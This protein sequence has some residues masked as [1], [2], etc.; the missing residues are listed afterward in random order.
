MKFPN[1]YNKQEYI[2]WHEAQFKSDKNLEAKLLQFR[3]QL[4]IDALNDLE[5]ISNII[6]S[7]SS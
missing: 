3:E 6:Q 5:L 4:K 7:V 1:K 2:A